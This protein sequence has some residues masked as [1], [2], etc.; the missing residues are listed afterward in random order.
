MFPV[1]QIGPL[2]IQSAGLFILVGFYFALLV[3]GNAAKAV[4]L[5][6]GKVENSI[7]ISA[8]AGL[9]GA[10]LGFL[11]QNPDV[12]RNNLGAIFSPNGSLL[13]LSSGI[14][15]SLLTA[16]ILLQ[17]YRLPVLIVLDATALGVAIQTVG[18]LLS[19]FASGGDLGTVTGLGWGLQIA[20]QVRHPVQVYE[21]LSIGILVTICRWSLRRKRESIPDGVTIFLTS[22]A[23]AITLLFMQVFHESSNYFY[24]FHSN[25]LTYLVILIISLISVEILFTRHVSK[26]KEE[27]V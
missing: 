16:A 18:V 8:A 25:Q 13:D 14:L 27:K 2:S 10:R 5:D 12:F 23:I 24:K 1:I 21:I 9:A 11:V 20:G 26:S 17:K 22:A 7:L 6:S 15:F 3:T 4:G 19:R